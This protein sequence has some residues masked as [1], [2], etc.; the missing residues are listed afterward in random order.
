MGGSIA[1]PGRNSCLSIFPD[2][3][4]DIFAASLLILCCSFSSLILSSVAMIF[5]TRLFL[6]RKGLSNARVDSLTKK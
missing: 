4:G 1:S 5:S 3:Q 6:K 2:D